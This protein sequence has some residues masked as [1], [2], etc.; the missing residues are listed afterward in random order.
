[1]R[2]LIVWRDSL[3]A[4]RIA[5]MQNA[6]AGVCV[7]QWPSY[8]V[9]AVTQHCARGTTIATLSLCLLATSGCL[10]GWLCCRLVLDPLLA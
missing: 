6:A 4:A 1:V 9:A 8:R 3:A 5:G 2:T 7:A 10:A